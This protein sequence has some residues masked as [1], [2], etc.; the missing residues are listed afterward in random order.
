M[1]SERSC[2]LELF[3]EYPILQLTTKVI[4]LA[5][6]FDMSAYPFR[7]FPDMNRVAVNSFE[8]RI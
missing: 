5:F 2:F 8:K 1:V 3:L 7:Y 6:Y 4:Q